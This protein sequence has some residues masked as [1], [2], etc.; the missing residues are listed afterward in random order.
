MK[1]IEKF[2]TL[3]SSMPFFFTVSVKKKQ[4]QKTIL[5]S[6]FTINDKLFPLR[7][8]QQIYIYKNKY[9]QNKSGYIV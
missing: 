1:L 5:L 3:F 6:N 2:E 8:L 4:Q 7:V 9:V